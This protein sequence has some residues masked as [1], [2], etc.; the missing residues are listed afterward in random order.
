LFSFAAPYMHIVAVLCMLSSRTCGSGTAKTVKICRIACH[1]Q[2]TYAEQVCECVTTIK[3]TSQ[4]V[5]K[6]SC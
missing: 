6:S 3:Q 1:I 2:H 5:H 4:N